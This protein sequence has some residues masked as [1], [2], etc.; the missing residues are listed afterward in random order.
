MSTVINVTAEDIAAGEQRECDF[1]PIALALRD[2][3]PDARVISVS[4]DSVDL[5]GIEIDLPDIAVEFIHAFD[6]GEGGEPFSFELDYPAV[7]P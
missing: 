7:S 5:D 1:C 6:G 3:F 4:P 2:A